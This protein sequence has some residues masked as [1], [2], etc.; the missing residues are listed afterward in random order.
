MDKRNSGFLATPARLLSETVDSSLS[1]FFRI[2]GYITADLAIWGA[3]LKILP[4]ATSWTALENAMLLVGVTGV[5]TLAA[6]T[7]LS[8]KALRA[9]YEKLPE[10]VNP[11][12]RLCRL[13]AEVYGLVRLDYRTHTEIAD[14]FSATVYYDLRIKA[15]TS[16]DRIEH[17]AG[18]PTKPEDVDGTIV[19]RLGSDQDKQTRIVFQIVRETKREL[20]V[21]RSMGPLFCRMIPPWGPAFA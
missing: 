10:D 4:A 8:Q 6:L 5:L 12:Q 11:H 2:V 17:F 19:T 21:C 16:L 18:I 13:D 1:G 20:S 7:F 15:Y 3:L 14:D 9:A